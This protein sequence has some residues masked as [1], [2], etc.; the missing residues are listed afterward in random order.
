[1]KN[2]A[3]I[4]IVVAALLAA[5]AIFS[6]LTFTPIA[7]IKARAFAASAGLLLLFAIAIEGLK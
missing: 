4:L 1:M 6:Q 7:Y 3:K 5:I 2:I